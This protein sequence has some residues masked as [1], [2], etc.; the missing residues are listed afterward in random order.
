MLSDYKFDC[1]LFFVQIT[2]TLLTS[3]FHMHIQWKSLHLV[4]ADIFLITSL[5]KV[6]VQLSLLAVF[7]DFF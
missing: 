5:T 7:A 6:I 2:S 3:S 4:D 1:Y